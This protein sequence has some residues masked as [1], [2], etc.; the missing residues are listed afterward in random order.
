MAMLEKNVVKKENMQGGKGTIT[1]THL[2]SEKEL[3]GKCA[4]F[5]K[6]TIPPGAVLGKH[7]HNGNTETYH[8]LSGEGLYDDNGKEIK[9]KPG[10]TTFCGDGESHSLTNTSPTEDLVFMALIINK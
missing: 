7:Q 10:D 3:A 8:I 1:I 6:V 2:L 5:A 4:M 9:V